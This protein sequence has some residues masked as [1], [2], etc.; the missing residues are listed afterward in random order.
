MRKS[1]FEETAKGKVSRHVL[2]T[3]LL[4]LILLFTAD[5]L[6]YI[7]IELIISLD[8]WKL[9]WDSDIVQLIILLATS[10]S[11]VMLFM[12]VKFK[13]KRPIS[14]LGLFK[15][16]ALTELS[17]GWLVGSVLFGAC[18]ILTIISGSGVIETVR[19]T[20]D[21][22]IWFLIFAV[23]WQVQSASVEILCRGWLLPVS[24]TKYSKIVSVSISSIFFGLLHS[25]NNH[26]SLISIFN[27]CLFGL[28]LSLYVILKGNIWGACGIH[29][30][31]NCVQ[32]SVFG[33]EVSG[34]P[35]L[36]NSLVH[37]KTYGADWISGGKFGVEGSMIT[38]I[39]LIVACYWLYQKSNFP[40][41]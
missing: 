2:L 33:I 12:W 25:A 16:G 34:E 35:M 38:S 19:F 32:G 15:E 14:S 40:Y 21:K 10:I 41:D 6:T 23:G 4:A 37:V 5:F 29:S 26:V 36:S 17:R 27:L 7:I 30:A 1:I 18:L 13:E 24:A 31:W 22:L 28:F 8:F 11:T 39:V 3:I 9:E 20:A